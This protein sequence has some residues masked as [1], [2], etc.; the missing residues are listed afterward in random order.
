MECWRSVR[1]V[2]ASVC[3]REVFFLPCLCCGLSLI[4]FALCVFFYDNV[5]NEM[6]YV[7]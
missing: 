7:Y 6:P 5:F 3:V 1:G 2:Y 4:W